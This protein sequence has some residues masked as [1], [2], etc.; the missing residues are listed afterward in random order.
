GHRRRRPPD[1]AVT[2]TLAPGNGFRRPDDRSIRD[3]TGSA[4][5]S[6]PAKL[7]PRWARWAAL[8]VFAAFIAIGLALLNPSPPAAVAAAGV[9][10]GAGALL[11]RG[12][13]PLLRYAAVA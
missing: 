12:W 13:R 6:S 4:G 9:A 11:V 3:M 10:V 1:G 5:S 7:L 2:R 8:A